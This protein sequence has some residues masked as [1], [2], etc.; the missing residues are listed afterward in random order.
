MTICTVCHH[1]CNLAQGQIGFCRARQNI[2]DIIKPIN[3][4]MLTSLA[5][6]PIEKKPL[7]RFHPGTGVLSLGS[8]GCNLHCPFCQ[9]YDIS[10]ADKDSYRLTYFA[11]ADIVAKAQKLKPQG[12]IGVAYTYNEPLICYEY[13]VDTGKLV[14]AAGMYNV[15]VTNGTASLEV[16]H[17]LQGVV[18]AYNIDLKGITQD[19]YAKLQGNLTMVQDFIT[20]VVPHSHVELTVLVVPG[21]N[22]SEAEMI[23]L[24]SWIAQLSPDLPLHV[25]RFF[26]RFE[27]DDHPATPV[28]TI[29]TLADVARRKLKYVYTGNC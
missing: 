10:M 20:A 23:E 9:N 13:I 3:Y 29:Y 2:N 11:P 15:V 14:H 28:K 12:N 21:E 5:F 26:P 18:D 27:W 19:Y 22:D 4:G 8:F 6:D 1:H 16:A 25:S 24:S 17:A 7:N